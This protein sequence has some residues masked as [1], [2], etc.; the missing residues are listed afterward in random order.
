MAAETEYG[1]TDLK[2]DEVDAWPGAA[3]VEFGTSWCGHC[4][5][6]QPAVLEALAAFPDVRHVKVEDGPGRPL[7][8]SYRVKLWPTLIFLKDGVEQS[9]VV[10]PDSPDAIRAELA[11]LQA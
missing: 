2:R 4:Q 10:R 9:R 6:A 8:R 3:V 1:H 5:G 11:G 7:G